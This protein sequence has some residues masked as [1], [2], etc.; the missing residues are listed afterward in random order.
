[1]RCL[2]AAKSEADR[3]INTGRPLTTTCRLK[4]RTSWLPTLSRPRF[5][6][7]KVRRA[8]RETLRDWLVGSVA[9]QLRALSGSGATLAAA[10]V[11]RDRYV[12]DLFRRGPGLGGDAILVHLLSDEAGDEE[13]HEL[14]DRLFLLRHEEVDAAAHGASTVRQAMQRAPE[15]DAKA[16]A[17]A[18]LKRAMRSS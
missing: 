12:R 8:R 14:I 6:S 10:G 2:S 15:I 3:C 5:E 17:A 11:I 13:E 16:Q 1:M 18:A 9:V 4:E 7:P